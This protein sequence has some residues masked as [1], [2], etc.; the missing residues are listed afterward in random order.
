MRIAESQ[1]PRN[2][3]GTDKENND[4]V[5]PSLPIYVQWHAKAV[6]AMEEWP[7]VA[8]ICAVT[9]KGSACQGSVTPR[10]L[11]MC[12]DMQRQCMPWK[13]GIALPIYVQWHAK[14]VHAM[15]VWPIAASIC[16]GTCKGSAC[17][18][19][20]THR[21]LYM[22]SDMQRQCMPWM[23]DPSL[24]LCVQWHAKAVHAVDVWPLAA[25]MCAVTCKGSACH[26]SVNIA[27]RFLA[28]LWIIIA[29]TSIDLRFIVIKKFVP[30]IECNGISELLK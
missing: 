1:D 18:G 12:R 6:H 22:C 8:Y 27:C 20:V 10:C 19:S 24:P 5:F 21:C 14:A 28:N 9:C 2:L 16:A 25:S 23:C 3:W 7:L 13:C 29:I 11:Y 15:E 4:K 30:N 26:G 17:H